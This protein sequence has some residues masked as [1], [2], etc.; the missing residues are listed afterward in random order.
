MLFRSVASL[1]SNGA[2]SGT[3]GTFGSGVVTTTLNA[4]ANITVVNLTVNTNATIS[5]NIVASNYIISG[6]GIY[7]SN[8]T[9]FSQGGVTSVTGTADQIVANPTSGAVT[10]SL[11]ASGIQNIP[12]GNATANTGTFT[13]VTAATV[14]AATIGNAGAQFTG[15]SISAAT[16]G[17]TGATH[18]GSIFTGTDA[19]FTT[20]VDRKSTRLNSSH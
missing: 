5:S 4:N 11:P 13:T 9:A 16:I 10:L 18:T 3:T 1:V 2:I 6:T 19:T 14:N 8:G 20:K 12:I 15:A 7:W 17:N